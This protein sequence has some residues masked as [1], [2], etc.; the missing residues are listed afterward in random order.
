MSRMIGM[1]DQIINETLSKIQHSFFLIIH[2]KDKF[3]SKIKQGVCFYRRMKRLVPRFDHHT[4]LFY[5]RY[6]CL[7][8]ECIGRSVL[9]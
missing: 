7:R 2:D 6:I 4:I 9:K 8:I 1:M 3:I 5:R